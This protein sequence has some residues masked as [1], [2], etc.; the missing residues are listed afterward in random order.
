MDLQ[1]PDGCPP[2]ID[3][4]NAFRLVVNCGSYSANLDYGVLEM[5]D[6]EHDLWINCNNGY[7]LDKFTDDMATLMIWGSSQTIAV[8]AVDTDS[9]AKWKLRRNE[10]FEKM[11][12]SRLNDRFAKLVVE[13]VLK[14]GYDQNFSSITSKATSGVTSQADPLSIGAEAVGD[15]HSSPIDI[16]FP[17]VDW[18][19]LIILPE[20]DQDGEAVDLVDEDRIFEA[21]GFKAADDKAEQQR[22]AAP[23]PAST[24]HID[25]EDMRDAS[26]DVNGIAPEE[27][28][29]DWDRDNPDMAVGAWM[30]SDWQLDSMLLSQ[31]LN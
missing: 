6:Q 8:W 3:P 12:Q 22:A 14:E 5:S 2:R 20:P 15:T 24:I 27:P 23:N 30:T 25:E 28:A 11:I 13:V 31:S 10:H 18:D 19:T 4:G 1:G 21:M 9:D 16:E 17:E 29:Q 7:N 26:I